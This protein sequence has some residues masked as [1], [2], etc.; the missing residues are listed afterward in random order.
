MIAK[1]YKVNLYK[2]LELYTTTSIEL[3][4]DAVLPAIIILRGMYFIRVVTTPGYVEYI[5]TKDVIAIASEDTDK[6][7]IFMSGIK[8]TSTKTN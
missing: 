1:L 3:E 8:M 7:T 6:T 5:E 4:G 2:M